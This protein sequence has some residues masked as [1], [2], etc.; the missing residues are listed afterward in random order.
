[1]NSFNGVSSIFFYQKIKSLFVNKDLCFAEGSNDFATKFQYNELV[2]KIERVSKVIDFVMMKLLCPGFV[3]PAVMV[4]L[5]NF[6]FYD[7]KGESYFI[8]FSIW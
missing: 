8:P 5:V 1:M 4:T 3:I 7:L 6:F 2:E